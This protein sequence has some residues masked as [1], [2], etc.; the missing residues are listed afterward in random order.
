MKKAIFLVILSSILILSFSVVFADEGTQTT[1]EGT[2][3]TKTPA[4]INLP[5]P[6]A[7]GTTHLTVPSLIGRVISGALG[8]VGS[9]ALLMFIYGGF[10]WML[11]GG[12]DKMITKGKD[13][14]MWAALGLVIIFMS[15]V[16]IHF[17]FTTLGV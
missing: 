12:N 10:M 3:T 17:I 14:L 7:S 11:S 8:V 13:T 6:L 2:Q 5:D 4:S 16:I 9:L 15:Y 1:K